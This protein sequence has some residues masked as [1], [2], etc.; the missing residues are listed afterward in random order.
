MYA[1]FSMPTLYD[2]D[3]DGDSVSRMSDQ[4]ICSGSLLNEEDDGDDSV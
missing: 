1:C 3:D 2:E 4:V